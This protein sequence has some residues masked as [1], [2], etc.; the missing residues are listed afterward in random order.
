MGRS[1]TAASSHICAR[2]LFH[3]T[4]ASRTSCPRRRASS[5][6]AP[7]L[8]DSRFRGNDA[9]LQVLAVYLRN[10]HLGIFRIIFCPSPT[11]IALLRAGDLADRATFLRNDLLFAENPTVPKNPHIFL[12]RSTP[13]WPDQPIALGAQQ[14]ITT[15]FASDGTVVIHPE[16]AQFFEVPIVLPL[17]ED[18]NFIP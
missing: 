12:T 4:D 16:P 8:L 9:R 6:H 3:K 1:T 15:F 11:K 10:G 18:L 17:P 13:G 2:C 5:S 14:Q 7:R